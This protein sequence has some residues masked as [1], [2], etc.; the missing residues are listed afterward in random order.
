MLLSTNRPVFKEISST[1]TLGLLR[2]PTIDNFQVKN[3]ITQVE[4]T[5]STANTNRKMLATTAS[6]F[7]PLRLLTPAVIAYKIFVQKLWQDKLQWDELLPAH[8]QQR[9]S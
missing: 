7:E 4:P 1:T 9:D 6:K 3:N 8:L 5:V 2:N